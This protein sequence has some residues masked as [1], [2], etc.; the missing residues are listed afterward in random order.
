MQTSEYSANNSSSRNLAVGFEIS[1]K[2]L[3]AIWEIVEERTEN[4]IE[5]NIE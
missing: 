2:I 5:D 1:K 3:E 4:F